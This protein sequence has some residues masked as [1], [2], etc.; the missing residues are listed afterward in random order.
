VT[1]DLRAVV[2]HARRVPVE[3][4]SDFAALA[5]E[6][7]S[8][9]SVLVDTCH[10][11]EVYGADADG[12]AP[13]APP[14]SDLL[15]GDAVARHV[16]RLAVGR[17]SVVIGEDQLLHQL[18][19]AV[20]AAR[21]RD[22]IPPRLDRLFDVALRAGRRA[23]S[24]LPA[25]RRS[26]ADVAIA[27]VLRREWPISPSVLVVGTGEMGRNAVE[28]LAA[29]G[30]AVAVASRTPERASAVAGL[31]G[32]VAVPFD[33][34][35]SIIERSAGVFV[36]LAGAWPLGPSSSRALSEA[37]AWVIDVSAPPA[38]A[39]SVADRLGARLISIDDLAAETAGRQ[40][41]ALLARL[42][43]LV[44]ESLD[45]YF[46]WSATE[47]QRDA[48]RSLEELA[49]AARV[50]ELSELWRR[51]PALEPSQR[52]EVERMARQLT[53]RLLREPLEQIGR[54]DEGRQAS[55]ARELFRL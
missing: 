5:R 44:E 29:R 50:A 51:V 11:V 32:G 19:R 33:P 13:D 6:R 3:P 42:D 26:L 55:A 30:I 31:V 46:R 41:E 24:W 37:A 28:A 43:R 12:L 1:A 36:A 27:E 49:T 16:M 34:G 47:T 15:A 54:D 25:R 9:G 20:Q 45:E 23:R 40:S 14:G 10:R 4:R 18:R 21:R 2:A 35:P 53:G 22:G 8:R 39:G 48:A 52:A 7:L 38:L 17:D